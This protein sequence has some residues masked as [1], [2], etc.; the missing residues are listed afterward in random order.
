MNWGFTSSMR[1][2]ARYYQGGGEVPSSQKE[3][4]QGGEWMD[5]LGLRVFH[6]RG[7]EIPSSQKESHREVGEIPPLTIKPKRKPS[8]FWGAI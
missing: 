8:E 7:G 4:H 3:N 1:E 6:Q 2:E 5:E